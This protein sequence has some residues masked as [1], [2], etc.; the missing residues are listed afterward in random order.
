MHATATLFAALLVGIPS[1][2][3]PGGNLIPA[4]TVYFSSC[5]E[6]PAPGEDSLQYILHNNTVILIHHNAFFNCA[7]ISSNLVVSETENGISI[8]EKPTFMAQTND[9]G[10]KG[11]IVEACSCFFTIFY[12]IKNVTIDNFTFTVN[13]EHGLTKPKPIFVDT[14]K[15][16]AGLIT[17][18]NIPGFL[19]KS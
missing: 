11:I 4:R 16:K 12:E 18:T 10:V 13:N 15:N 9:H 5:S 6:N 1:L 8:T 14:S 3:A 19:R 17:L 7:A 2:A